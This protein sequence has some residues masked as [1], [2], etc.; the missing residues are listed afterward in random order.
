MQ[1]QTIEVSPREETGK[2]A[3]RRLR[4]SGQVP[5]VVYGGGKEAKGSVPIRVDR[6]KIEDLLK[7]AGE[8]AVFLLELAGTD[9]SRHT[10]IKELQIDTLT[11][12]MIHID[13]QRVLLDQVVRVS[14]P[15][16][17]IGEASG[18]R[19]E[20]GLLDF[21]TREIE[22]ES[23]P[24][25][26]PTHI[27][28]DVTELN[29]GQHVEAGELELPEGVKLL[30]DEERVVVSVALRKVVEEEVEEEDELLTAEGEEPE[31]VGEEEADES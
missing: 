17:I 16:E 31:L 21:V 18:V 13:F 5:A 9:Q 6:R 1:E 11:G 14:V 23:L 3:N 2:N 15:I 29:I 24:A 27:E 10:M 22:I 30:A 26:I 19:N 4:A 25:S 28:L 20:G 8:N 12:E 7:I